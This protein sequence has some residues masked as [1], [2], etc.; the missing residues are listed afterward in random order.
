MSRAQHRAMHIT[1]LAAADARGH[2][3]RAH[4]VRE[5]LAAD[6]V[7]VD[8][9]TTSE[10]GRA[11]L[12]ALGTPSR[13]LSSHYGVA[14][15]ERQNMARARTEACVLKY[16]LA[17]RRGAAD[18]A[19]LASLSRHASLVVN[20]FHP[21]LLTA[22]L[23]VLPP[24]VHVYG[25]NL[26]RA[27][28]ENFAGRLPAPLA[29]GFGALMRHLRDRAY[30]RIEHTFDVPFPAGERAGTSFRLPPIVAAPSREPHVVRRELGVG[31]RLA[32][33][34]LNPHFRDP[35]IAEAIERAL[36][37]FVVHAVGEGFATRPGWRAHDARFVDVAAAADVLVSAPGMG[38][39]SIARLCGTPLAALVTDQPEQQANLRF[40]RGTPHAAL[41]LGVGLEERLRA[42]TAHLTVPRARP[43][44]ATISAIHDRWARVLGALAVAHHPLTLKESA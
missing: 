36:A 1:W 30:A 17:P 12:Y 33:V 27:I 32:A 23:G 13:I 28:E 24:I 37:G 8:V 5:R 4:L 22:P 21:L 3:M 10:A 26:F 25:E 20:D 7:A 19:R 34:Y 9:V 42:S 43:A 18:L 6:G 29:G 11:F 14:F 44:V 40:L 31:E 41:A 15:D 39:V 35:R 16:L 38:A 2:L